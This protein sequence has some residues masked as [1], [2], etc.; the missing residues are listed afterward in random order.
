MTTLQDLIR[1]LAL[2]YGDNSPIFATSLPDGTPLE[3]GREMQ[4]MYREIVGEKNGTTG[5]WFQCPEC[6]TWQVRS[7]PA[8]SLAISDK[9]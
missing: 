7:I 8:D 3:T 5:T 6:S 4:A 9:P 1:W 2:P